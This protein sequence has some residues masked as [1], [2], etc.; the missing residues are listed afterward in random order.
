MFEIT[1]S[2]LCTDGTGSSM[3]KLGETNHSAVQ[4]QNVTHGVTTI[5]AN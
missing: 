5:S 1:S 3:I 2:L 4:I